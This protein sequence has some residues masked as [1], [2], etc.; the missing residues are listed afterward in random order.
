[1][2]EAKKNNLFLIWFDQEDLT[3]L[4]TSTWDRQQHKYHITTKE[5]QFKEGLHANAKWD[6]LD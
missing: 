2:C 6:T 4:Q 3:E 5:R 1:M